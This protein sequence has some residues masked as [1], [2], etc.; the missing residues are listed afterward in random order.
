MET[1]VMLYIEPTSVDMSKA[2]R[3]SARGDPTVATREKGRTVV[4]SLV[5]SVLQDVKDL[6]GAALPAAAPASIRPS[7][8]TATVSVAGPPPPPARCTPGDERE[9]RGI[10]D[11]FSTAWVNADAIRLGGLWSADGDIVHPDGTIEHGTQVITQNRMQLF[12]QR[13]YRAT[14]HPLAIGSVRCLSPDV[15]VADGKWEL[16][17]ITDATGQPVPTLEGLCTLVV[18]KARPG[19]LI[20]AYRYNIKHA[21]GA[22]PTLLQRPGWPVIR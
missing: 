4:E 5:A 1:S 18:K 6:R 20:E 2:A 13:Q 9:I 14:R 10:A 17:G 3:D 21:A 16:R 7:A 15:A 11:A 22:P 8:P 19:W 12:L